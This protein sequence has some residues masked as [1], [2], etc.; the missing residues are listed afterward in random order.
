LA[1][2]IGVIVVLVCVALGL[3]GWIYDA[4]RRF[5][6]FHE[7]ETRAQIEELTRTVD[8]LSR[9]LDVAQ[10]I[11]DTGAARL[12]MEV[13]TQEKLAGM[14]KSLEDENARLKADVAVF[15]SLAGTDRAK[16]TLVISRVDVR[17]DDPTGRYRY[18]MLVAKSGTDSQRD[19][20]GHLE[21]LV[22]V[23][24][25][26]Q[27]VIIKLPAHDTDAAYEVS[28]RYFKRLEG[29][30]QLSQ[31]DVIE[32]VEAKL[33]EAGRVRASQMFRP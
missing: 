12:Q 29:I 7:A 17:P 2:R 8:K 19:F 20:N 5:A 18:R 9:E 10:G 28:F 3:A 27:T 33:V 15:E 25:G 16:P 21:F 6:G 32:S 13:T 11:A 24:R 30:I 31:G 14:V 22:T 4:G 23:R 1:W 26:V